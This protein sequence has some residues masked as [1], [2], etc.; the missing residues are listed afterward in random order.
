MLFAKTAI[1]LEWI[2]V[3]V[4]KR[5]RN[6]FFW[7]CSSIIGANFIKVIWKLNLTRKRKIGVSIIFSVGV[8]A[9]IAGTG[10]VYAVVTLNYNGDATYGSS[11]VFLWASTEATFVLL[12]FCIPGVP[13][14]FTGAKESIYKL[15]GSFKSWSKSTL[16]LSKDDTR[17][18]NE[19]TWQ[20]SPNEGSHSTVCNHTDKRSEIPL[21]NLEFSS[22]KSLTDVP[23]QGRILRTTEFW[24]EESTGQQDTQDD[25]SVRQHP[26]MRHDE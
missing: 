14:A 6:S 8:L 22:T 25:P 23:D 16:T 26:W 11:A 5:Q 13:K 18:G 9:C 24:L 10:R 15:A 3:F 19:Q 2:R 12:A 21:T 1:L 7:I 4:P 20:G 17:L